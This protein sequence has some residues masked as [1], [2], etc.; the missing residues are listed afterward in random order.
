MPTYVNNSRSCTGCLEALPTRKLLAAPCGHRYCPLCLRQL[1]STALENLE[2][3]PAKCCRK[4][5]PLEEV[6]SV[7]NCQNEK[8]YIEQWEEQAVLPQERVYCP[9]ANCGRWINPKYQGKRPG[10][11]VCPHCKTRIC[12]RCRKLAHG[13]GQCLE[14]EDTRAVLR[15]AKK[16]MWQRC[17]RCHFVVDKIEGCNHIVCRCGH[18]FWYVDEWHCAGIA[19]DRRLK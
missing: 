12:P 15:L 10:T 7:M 14:D 2:Y 11:H 1:A 6:L 17:N 3:F 19:T 13:Q 5:I 9:R 4:E 8:R 16:N 18:E